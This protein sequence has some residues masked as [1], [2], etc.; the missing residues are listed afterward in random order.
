MQSRKSGPKPEQR[1]IKKYPNRRLYDTETSTYITL[2]EV[3][4][5]V[6][7]KA[8]FVVRDAKTGDDLT[9]SIL[10]QIILEEEAGGAPMFTEQA[11]ASI[12]RFYGQ[13]MHG[14]MGPYLEKNIQAMTEMQ[15]QLAEKAE[16]LTP[17]MWAKFMTLQS[18]VLQGMMGSYV[19][20]SKGM[21]LQMQE[22]MK[23]NTEQV[24]GAF[25]IKR[26]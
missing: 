14:Y 21:F 23:K 11:L 20:Q 17:E 9:R 2:A 22:Q 8:S 5:L 4:Q 6:M 19:E 26:P 25:G 3:K 15:A 7:T 12:I 24:L 18:P 13:A 16:G 1:V 10:L